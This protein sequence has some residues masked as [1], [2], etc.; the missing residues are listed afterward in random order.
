NQ[1]ELLSVL[2]KLSANVTARLKRKQYVTKNVSVMIKYKNRE[3]ITRS[4]MLDNPIV[5]P[6]DIFKAAKALFIKNWN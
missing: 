6:H 5:E 4:R 2:E 3:T 1:S